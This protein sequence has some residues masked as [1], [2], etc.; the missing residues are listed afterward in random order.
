M[1]FIGAAIW[2]MGFATV[3]WWGLPGRP[4]S[5]KVIAMCSAILICAG[6]AANAWMARI[7]IDPT[8]VAF[9][10]A[11]WGWRVERAAIAGYRFRERIGTF[12]LEVPAMAFYTEQV[13]FDHAGQPYPIPNVL[14]NR[15]PRRSWIWDL[16]DLDDIT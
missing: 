7:T 4:T 8:S 5:W 9:T 16:A 12:L 13:L 3:H 15:L 10:T 6:L 2:F 11:F 1:L 14:K